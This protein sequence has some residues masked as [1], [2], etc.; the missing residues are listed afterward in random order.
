MIALQLQNV[1]PEKGKYQAEPH[2]Q[3]PEWFPQCKT[4]CGSV[5]STWILVV[6]PANAL[7]RLLGARGFWPL[8]HPF[9]AD[10]RLLHQH[11]QLMFNPRKPQGSRKSEEL[12]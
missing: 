8:P 10:S 9:L 12:L 3:V 1:G 5:Q 7:G 11:Q 2:Y 4:A 6:G